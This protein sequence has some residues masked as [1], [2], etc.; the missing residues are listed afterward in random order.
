MYKT[1]KTYTSKISNLCSFKKN[2]SGFGQPYFETPHY[3]L[4]NAIKDLCY[5]LSLSLL[6]SINLYHSKGSL[7]RIIDLKLKTLSN[8]K[9]ITYRFYN[10]NVHSYYIHLAKLLFLS[11]IRILG[12]FKRQ[13]FIVISPFNKFLYSI[14]I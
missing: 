3:S 1:S 2:S 14:I 7:L 13:N 11:Y 9:Q 12:F 5:C 8:L 6:L 10:S 4:N